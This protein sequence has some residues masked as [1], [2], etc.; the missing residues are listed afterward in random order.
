MM[1]VDRDLFGTSASANLSVDGRYRYSLTR[2]W[3]VG[4]GRTLWVM[5]NPST[6]D[7]E[8]DDPTIRRCIGFSRS[9]GRRALTVINLFALRATDPRELRAVSKSE[10]IGPQNNAAIQKAAIGSDVR[11]IV[12]AWGANGS[13]HARDE[14]V[15][16]LLQDIGGALS[17]LQLTKARQPRHPLYLLA[18]LKPQPWA[19]PKDEETKP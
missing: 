14:Y 17:C 4:T 5:L 15:Y 18:T 11:E 1:S 13:L 2:D 9:W 16:A 19:A 8:V 7:A 12:C 6:A 10:A 3:V